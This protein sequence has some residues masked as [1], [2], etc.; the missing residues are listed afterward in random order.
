MFLLVNRS[1]K[2]SYF[3]IFF[4]AF[5][6]IL[7]IDYVLALWLVKVPAKAN[8]FIILSIIDMLIQS[9]MGE[10]LN[11]MVA[12]TG[13][14]RNFQIVGSFNMLLIIPISYMFLKLDFGPEIVF[15]IIV[16]SGVVSGFIRLY[17]AHVQTGYSY[18]SY[19]KDVMLPIMKFML[20][21]LPIPLLLKYTIFTH[22]TLRSFSLSTMIT[23]II[24]AIVVYAIGLTSVERQ[25]L[26]G[27]LR[28]KL[29]QK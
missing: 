11:T 7:N 18:Y 29:K 14:I 4:L 17:Y 23:L 25:T 26:Y 20:A 22:S 5:P 2:F 13:R 9:I 12:A 15:V 1:L 19:L 27:V 16:F 21:V 10:Q 3:I 6:V 8:I 28:N 24:T